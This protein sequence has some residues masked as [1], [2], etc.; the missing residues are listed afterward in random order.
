MKR[1][2]RLT[3]IV[4]KVRRRNMDTDGQWDGTWDETYKYGIHDE[5]GYMVAG[6]DGF[7]TAEQA[8]AAGGK[9]LERWEEK[10]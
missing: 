3:L 8:E 5:D 7:A 10:K 6:L 2:K 4:I 1:L 9:A